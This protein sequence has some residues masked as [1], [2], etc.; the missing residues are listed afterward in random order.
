MNETPSRS[1]IERAVIGCL[2]FE[3][4]AIDMFSGIGG[5]A[6]WFSG[7]KER[8]AASTI[9]G[10]YERGKIAA[11]VMSCASESGIDMEWL[12]ACVDAIPT[13]AHAEYYCTL[14]KGHAEIDEMLAMVR[15]IQIAT[16]KASPET[17][18]ETRAS[19]EATIHKTLCSESTSDMTL[20]QAAH[21]WINRVTDRT[22]KQMLDWPCRRITDNIGRIDGELIW[23]IAQPS[24]GKTAF[25]LQWLTRLADDGHI[26]SM[27][28]LESSIIDLV[29]RV[30]MERSGVKPSL[31][32]DQHPQ[33]SHI[34]HARQAAD[35]LSDL[36]RIHDSGMTM[37]QVYAWGRAEKRKGSKL[38]IIDNTRHIRMPGYKSRVDA[39]ADMSVRLKALRDDTRLP[40]VVLHH[41]NK[42]DDVSW[43]SDVRRDADMLIFLREDENNTVKPTHEN[44]DGEWCVVFDVEKHREGRKDVAI[45]LRFDKPNMRF[46]EW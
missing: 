5:A 38:L 31:L 22:S 40:V 26:T 8:R 34:D 28:S 20:K 6:L 17:A 44:P 30:L 33:Q 12:E 43:S 18:G 36:V 19:I 7:H 25:V 46:T 15:H 35:K 1:E 39:M 41:S 45:L 14:L 10:R 21:E 37:D 29:P 32:K 4:R 13:V 23:I 42:E 24:V 27:L 11:D 9:I 16:S 2:L 3:E